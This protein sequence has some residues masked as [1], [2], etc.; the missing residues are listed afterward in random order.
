MLW[1]LKNIATNTTKNQNHT[2]TANVAAINILHAMESTFF[3]QS[4][5]SLISSNIIL[6]Q[7]LFLSQ[8]I[9]HQSYLSVYRDVLCGKLFCYNGNGHPNYGRLVQ[10]LE[11]KA[12]F[13]SHP[14]NDHGQ[15]E[16]GTKCGEGMVR[17][18]SRYT[19]V[20]VYTNFLVV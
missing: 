9:K 11:C 14:E 15:V 3:H 16:T 7:L 5:H 17:L 12:T 18:V 6:F 1:W 2:P 8:L 13:Y 10:F 20:T 4:V 19:P